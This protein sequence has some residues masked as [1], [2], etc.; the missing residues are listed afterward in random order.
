MQESHEDKSS[1]STSRS[2]EESNRQEEVTTYINP[3]AFL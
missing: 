2:H 3:T 1:Q